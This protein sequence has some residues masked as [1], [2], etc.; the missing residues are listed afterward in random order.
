MDPATL[1]LPPQTLRPRDLLDSVW[2][3]PG[4]IR[5][6]SAALDVQKDAYVTSV[7]GPRVV[8]FRVHLWS[9]PHEFHPQNFWFA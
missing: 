2:P 5:S 1:A 7:V 6:A 9:R 8:S 3:Y 4:Q